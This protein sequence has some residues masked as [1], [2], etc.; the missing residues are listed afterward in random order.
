MVYYI[1][2][3]LLS[4]V[5]L[6]ALVDDQTPVLLGLVT[7]TD[8]ADEDG[9]DPA[10]TL[11]VQVV[12]NHLEWESHRTSHSLSLDPGRLLLIDLSLMHGRLLI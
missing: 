6:F 4:W 5:C 11:L 3:A 8:V 1:R 10:D 9:N 2:I 12:P 7:D